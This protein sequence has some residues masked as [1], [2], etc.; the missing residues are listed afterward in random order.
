MAIGMAL[1]I[2]A[3]ALAKNKTVDQVFKK[4]KSAITK[5]ENVQTDVSSLQSDMD[6]SNTYTE[7]TKNLANNTYDNAYYQSL[8]LNNISYNTYIACLY[9]DGTSVDDCESPADFLIDTDTLFDYEISPMSIT[10]MSI[11]SLGD[12]ERGQSITGN[13]EQIKTK[14]NNL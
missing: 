9:A 8:L 13:A 1:S 4:V 5:I 11:Q 2:S 14:L 3:P 7:Y 6:T 12:K 10:G